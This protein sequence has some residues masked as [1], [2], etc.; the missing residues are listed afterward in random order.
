MKAKFVFENLNEDDDMLLQ[1]NPP[2][3]DD[4]E[5]FV[6]DDDPMMHDEFETALKNELL[7]KDYSRRPVSFRLKGTK[8]IIDAVPMADLGKGKYL[9]RVGDTYK[10]FDIN[11]IVE[12]SFKG[13]E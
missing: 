10:K 4:G 11:D 12:E 7:V 9:M 1:E 3:Y 5:D 6:E 2:E 8:D 13:N